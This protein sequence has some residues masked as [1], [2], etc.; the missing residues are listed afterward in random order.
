MGSGVSGVVS[1][2]TKAGQQAATDLGT[3]AKQAGSDV[4]AATNGI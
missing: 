3:A 1:T 4:K 2:A